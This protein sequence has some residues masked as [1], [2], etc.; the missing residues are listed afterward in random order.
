M[1]ATEN[2]QPNVEKMTDREVVDA[3]LK[4]DKEVTY[5]YLYKTCYPLFKSIYIKYYTDC[6]KCVEFIND[7]YVQILSPGKTTGK[8]PLANFKFG[9]SLTFWLKQIAEN[10]CKGLYK[11]RPNAVSVGN[12][13][14]NERLIKLG[15]AEEIDLDSINKDDVQ[16]VLNQIKPLRFRQIIEHRYL[17]CETN[18]EVAKALNMTRNNFNTKHFIA[19]QKMVNV[20]K[21]EGLL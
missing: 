2:Q 3:I 9:C 4:R 7:I 6:D 14:S 15:G 21:Q 1:M 10:R 5:E 12:D 8:I 17:R 11:K 18:E 19:R 16:K 20:L 13:I